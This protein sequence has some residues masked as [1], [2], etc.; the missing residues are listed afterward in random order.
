[1]VW[2]ILKALTENY[3][4]ELEEIKLRNIFFSTIIDFFEEN[5]EMGLPLN[6]DDVA[7]DLTDNL[8]EAY[9]ISKRMDANRINGEESI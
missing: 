3:M 6:F 8:I 1:M 2:N 9:E 7:Y 5:T 4:N